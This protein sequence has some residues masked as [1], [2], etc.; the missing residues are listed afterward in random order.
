MTSYRLRDPEYIDLAFNPN[1]PRD[2]HGR[3]ASTGGVAKAAVGTLSTKM[4]VSSDLSGT[5][6]IKNAETMYGTGSRQHEDAVI[7]FG[8]PEEKA[9]YFGL[10]T[11]A[12][13]DIDKIKAEGRKIEEKRPLT[14][15]ERKQQE[16]DAKS[17]L[18]LGQTKKGRVKAQVKAWQ[19]DHEERKAMLEDTDDPFPDLNDA[20]LFQKLQDGTPEER[21]AALKSLNARK[22][23]YAFLAEAAHNGLKTVRAHETLAK[24][25]SRIEKI[26]GG[27]G[28]LKMRDRLL[29]EKTVIRMT[30]G[31]EAVKEK[32]KESLAHVAVSASI[33]GIT[34]AIAGVVAMQH[35]GDPESFL[36]AKE[37]VHHWMSSG[38][39]VGPAPIREVGSWVG[40]NAVVVS[41]GREAA[42]I[43]PATWW[44]NHGAKKGN[45]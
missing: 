44:K 31:Y 37:A 16:E 3:F 25:D 15:K 24:F 23:R 28:F 35:G 34:A 33:V 29:S 38:T 32:A 27:K 41:L 42:R 11:T 21:E 10:K 13:K 9:R 20:D 30:R 5:A 39:H 36:H 45:V 19:A 12:K 4:T 40:L 14:R 26:P 43:N 1:Q 7:A 6:K 17:L 18:E 22:E 2:S 8:T